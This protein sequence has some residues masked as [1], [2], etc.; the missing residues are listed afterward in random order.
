MIKYPKEWSNI[1]DH[2][3]QKTDLTVVTMDYKT[4]EYQ[5]I[6][7]LFRLTMP[8]AVIKGIQRIQNN[9][10]WKI[11]NHQ[12]DYVIKKMNEEQD[13]SQKN[14]QL[15]DVTRLLFHGTSQTDP[16]MIY[17]SEEGFDMRFSNEGMWGRAN[18]FA[19]KS[20]YS[21]NY[22]YK[23][24]MKMILPNSSQEQTIERRKMFLA[25][26]L[27]GQTIA[28]ASDKTLKMPPL[29]PGETTKR[30]DSVKGFTNGSDVYMVYS[31]K[32]CYPNYLITYSLV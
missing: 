24:S 6:A 16:K 23:T 32:N 28:L 15:D 9:R 25:R 14:L 11:F 20:A 5:E 10:L 31:N 12:S 27:V 8:T 21:N 7:N 19:V 29:L 17:E 26:V 18:Y 22:C 3:S 30:Y 1:E 2:L 13:I 4:V